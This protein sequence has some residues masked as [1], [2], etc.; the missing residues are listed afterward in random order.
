MFTR[1]S[2]LPQKEKEMPP[3]R[4]TREEQQ[5]ARALY[6]STYHHKKLERMMFTTRHFSA[7]AAMLTEASFDFD[8]A[9]DFDRLVD[10]FV[11]N[12]KADNEKFNEKKFINTVY[13]E[14]AWSDIRVGNLVIGH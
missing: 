12:L 13:H 11:R 1:T 4:K 3:V 2:P 8:N 10:L 14:A 5:I 9:D 6:L 7:I